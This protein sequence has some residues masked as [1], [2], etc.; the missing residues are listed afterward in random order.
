MRE[1]HLLEPG[2]KADADLN[3]PNT[4]P[5]ADLES[6]LAEIA[7]KRHDF[8]SRMDRNGP[9]IGDL[10]QC[11]LWRG[12]VG[13]NGYGRFAVGGR[14]VA[15]HRV[16]YCL[17]RAIPNPRLT[18]DHLCRMRACVNPAHLEEVSSRVNLFRGENLAARRRRQTHCF[19]G[20][21]LDGENLH[22]SKAGHRGCRACKSQNN[23]RHRREWRLRRAKTR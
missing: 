10:G 4:P 9:A 11:W 21:A 13:R 12:R 1:E 8:E 17:Y 3:H 14:E 18:L 15:A 20:H 23:R 7:A 2:A 5:A 16:S 6:L 19:R 22:W